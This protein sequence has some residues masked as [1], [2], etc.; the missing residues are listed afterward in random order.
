MAITLEVDSDRYKVTIYCTDYDTANTRGQKV[1]GYQGE[2]LP[3]KP[4]EETV[5]YKDGVHYSWE[6]TGDEPFMYFAKNTLQFNCVASGLFIQISDIS[7]LN[8]LAK[9]QELS[10]A[11]NQINDISPL[12]GLT[13][14]QRL[15]MGGNWITDI[16]PLS[17]LAELQVLGWGWHNNW[18]E[19]QIS[20]I[21]PFSSLT[22]LRKLYLIGR[23]IS[24]ISPL[25]NLT[26]LEVLFLD[27][28]GITSIS[29]LQGLKKIGQGEWVG[30][31][32]YRPNGVK[33]HLGLS[34]NQI[35]DISPL[36]KNLGIGEGDGVDLRRN[37]LNDKAYSVH[38][39]TL[40]KRGVTVLFDPKVGE[41]E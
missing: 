38:I 22:K 28:S 3:D 40:E 33:I 11:G 37:P 29:A 5:K 6:V 18:Q 35:S 15:Y 39:P 1:Y 2:T 7:P 36:V 14:L 19:N 17:G 4:D 9:L 34:F 13:K 20:D 24:D 8:G 27:N 26:D 41:W 21:S 25:A 23:Q 31:S 16:I 32:P 30:W 12:S 10:L